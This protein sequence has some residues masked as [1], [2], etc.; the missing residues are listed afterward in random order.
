MPRDCTIDFHQD[1]ITYRANNVMKTI[2]LL[3]Y[4]AVA[5]F[6]FSKWL[7]LGNLHFKEN[8]FLF[9]V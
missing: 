5:A 6:I 9:L 1:M 2:P 7:V 8:K 3:F 4:I